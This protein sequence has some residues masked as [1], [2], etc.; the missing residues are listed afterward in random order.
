MPVD[1]AA[2]F[3]RSDLPVIDITVKHEFMLSA[4]GGVVLNKQLERA[5][6][7]SAYAIVFHSKRLC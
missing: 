7:T 3:V 6:P 2:A 4:S 5:L 1:S